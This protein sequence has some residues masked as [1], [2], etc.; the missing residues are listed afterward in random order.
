[1]Q[2]TCWL[3]IGSAASAQVNEYTPSRAERKEGRKVKEEKR[4]E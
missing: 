4:Q 2:D 1:M 3:V